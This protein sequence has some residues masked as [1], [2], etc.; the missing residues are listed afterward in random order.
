MASAAI[1]RPVLRY[2]G[3]KFRLAS[4]LIDIFP[5]HRVYTEAFG[6]GASILM[7]KSRAYSEVYNDLDGEVVN[8]FRV[9]QDRRKAKRLE[10]LI[11]LTPFSRRE[12]ELSYKRAKTDIERARRTIIRSFMGFGSD[13]ISRMKASCAGFNARISS[14][15]CTGFR[16]KS[17]RSGTTPAHDGMEWPSILL[18]LGHSASNGANLDQRA[19]VAAGA[20]AALPVCRGLILAGTNWHSKDGAI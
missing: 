11:R 19:G 10:E 8:V 15:M 20:S 1:S 2:H 7:L 3:G 4:R 9:L 6:G 13:A 14:T 16:W 18:E 12:F 5:E 17:E